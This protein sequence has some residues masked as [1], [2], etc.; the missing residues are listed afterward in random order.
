[1]LNTM[2]CF[3]FYKYGVVESVF[4]WIDYL[5]DMFSPSVVNVNIVAFRIVFRFSKSCLLIFQHSRLR[6]LFGRHI[7]KQMQNDK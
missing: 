5:E 7:S 3:R 6:R 1:M 2:N 4:Q